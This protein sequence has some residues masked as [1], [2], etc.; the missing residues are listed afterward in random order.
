MDKPG[1]P[2]CDKGESAVMDMSSENTQDFPQAFPLSLPVTLGS[3]VGISGLLVMIGWHSHITPIVQIIPN[4]TAMVYNTALAFVLS[5]ISL[6]LL[7]RRVRVPVIFL[8]LIVLLLGGLALYQYISGTGIGFDEFLMKHWDTTATNIPGSM[9]P[10]TALCFALLGASLA[11]S[12]AFKLQQRWLFGIAI[13]GTIVSSLGAIAVLGYLFGIDTAYGWGKLTKMAPHTAA[14]IAFIGLGMAAYARQEAASRQFSQRNWLPVLAGLWVTTGTV[15]M[16]QAVYLFMPSENKQFSA[17]VFG[18]GI[19]LAALLGASLSLAQSNRERRIEVDL[20]NKA[21]EDKAEESEQVIVEL[22]H[23]LG[24]VRTL[25]GMLP[26][27]ANCKKIRDDKGY[28]QQIESYIADH[29]E[30]EFSHGLCPECVKSLYP[31]FAD[32]VLGKK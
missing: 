31:D 26:I 9:A 4:T 18:A 25:S 2:D 22:T 3:L 20:L 10:N 24:Q 32:D 17:I 29:S 16:W 11:L 15:A 28:W 30:A 1:I 27:C 13:V 6:V 21:L 8:A 12:S 7:S 19:L 23:L 14:C 5:G